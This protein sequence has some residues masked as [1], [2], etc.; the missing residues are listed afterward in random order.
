MQKYSI[1][2]GREDNDLQ[3][4][5]ET[6][7]TEEKDTD[8]RYY[9][10]DEVDAEIAALKERVRELE[11]AP[12]HCLSESESVGILANDNHR[13]REALKNVDRELHA[14]HSSANDARRM[15]REALKEDANGPG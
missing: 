3:A 7:F 12:K 13:L 11:A 2:I 1:A 14:H 15:I 5:M 4:I 6:H 8:G 9:I 10:V